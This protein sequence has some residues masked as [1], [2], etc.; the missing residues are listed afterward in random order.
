LSSFNLFKFL[1][2]LAGVP[3]EDDNLERLIKKIDIKSF[4]KN[5]RKIDKIRE[6]KHSKTSQKKKRD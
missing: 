5:A 2:D 4:Q 6:K 1:E 3:Q